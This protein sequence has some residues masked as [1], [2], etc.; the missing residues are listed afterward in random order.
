MARQSACVPKQPRAERFGDSPADDEPER[1]HA[2]GV[3][4]PRS[5]QLGLLRDL[6]DLY[7]PASFTDVTWTMRSGAHKP[8]ATRNFSA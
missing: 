7:L 1:L 8:S 5:G 3:G 4:D 6:Q 2:D